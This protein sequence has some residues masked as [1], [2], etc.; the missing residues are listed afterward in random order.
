MSWRGRSFVLFVF[1]GFFF[2]NKNDQDAIFSQI[3]KGNY[4]VVLRSGKPEL[5][6]RLTPL[7]LLVEG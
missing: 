6:N 7:P 3:E 1:L 2:F 4:S 5:S